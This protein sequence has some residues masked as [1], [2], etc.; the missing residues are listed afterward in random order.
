MLNDIASRFNTLLDEGRR[1]EG[2]LGSQQM[3]ID[4]M[5]PARRVV[6]S[7]TWITSA[8]NLI[9]IVTLSGSYYRDEIQRTLS[10]QYLKYGVPIPVFHKMLG[11]L[12]SAKQEWDAGFLRQVEYIV[13]A[14][15]FDKFLDHASDYHKGNK[16]MEASILASAVLED[17][18]KRIARKN[19]V[20]ASGNSLEELI[21]TLV[22]NSVFTPVKAK[23][24]KAYAGVRNSALHA[25]WNE[26]DIRDVG[27][28]ISGTR[29]LIG[30]HL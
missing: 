9:Q 6:E 14:E 12:I 18:I 2:V 15:T 27:L 26:I 16:K 4:D 24:Y 10:H 7:Q 23:Q 17:T 19:G 3:P 13:A 22:K 30:V 11:L 21:D 5:I 8:A 20:D 1:L 28:L 25:E 29:E